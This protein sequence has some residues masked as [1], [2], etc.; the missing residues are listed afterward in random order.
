MNIDCWSEKNKNSQR[1]HDCY[2]TC[3]YEYLMLTKIFGC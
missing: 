3:N 2:N 1:C